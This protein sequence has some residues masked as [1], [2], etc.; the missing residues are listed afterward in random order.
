MALFGSDAAIDHR[1]FN[2]L[3]DGQTGEQIEVLKNEANLLTAKL[4]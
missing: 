1:E 4:G 3:L 2:I